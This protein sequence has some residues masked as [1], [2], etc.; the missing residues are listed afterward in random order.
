MKIIEFLLNLLRSLFGGKKPAK[1][2]SSTPAA[3]EPELEET[4]TEPPD[5][6]EEAVDDAE[7]DVENVTEDDETERDALEK[8]E[9]PEQEVLDEVEAAM[10]PIEEW[11][12]RQRALKDLGHYTGKIDGIP[13]RKTSAAMRACEKELGLTVDGEWDRELQREVE[14]ALKN[15]SKPAIK[16]L[17]FTPPPGIAYE[18]MIDPSEY[19]LD[20]AFFN[21]FIDLT[22]KSN[23]E[24]DKGRRRKGT[25]KFTRLVRFCWH[26]TAFIWRPYLVSKAQKRYTT[27][28]KMNAHI[29]FDVD[30]MIIII[31]NFFYYLWT[32]NA[33]NPDCISIEVLGNF[34]GIQGSGKWY[35]GDKFGRVRPTREQ[36]IRCRQFTIWMLDPE[37]GPADDKL[38]K[39]LLEWR[40]G[41]RE[42]G[43]PLKKVNTH[44]ESS[45]DRAGDCG[46][47]LW[48]HVGEWTMAKTAMVHGEKKGKGETLPPEWSAKPP[49]PPLPP[50][51]S[52]DA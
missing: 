10:V 48:Y 3:P 49:A 21:C 11:K 24:T 20:D 29:L 22:A 46:S 6:P 36:I 2:L 42:H 18:D 7:Y 23:V 52:V 30:G 19:E 37:Q 8:D 15:K 45:G 43:N 39:P 40:L 47:E 1:E 14:K 16:P 28:H 35:K 4:P 32:A 41:V 27:H 44:R 17:P 33:F 12:D 13:G 5:E 25:R 38:P 50:A 31:H 34:E 9:E 26:Q 51:G